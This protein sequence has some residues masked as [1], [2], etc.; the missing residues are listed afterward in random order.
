MN[1][2]GILFCHCL[3]VLVTCINTEKDLKLGKVK[4]MVPTGRIG[5]CSPAIGPDGTVYI[6]DNEGY[7]Y[8][9]VDMDS[10][11]TFKWAPVK[12]ETDLGECCPTLTSD[13][14]R[15]YIGS[16]T[17]PASMFCINTDDGSLHWKYT[18]PPNQTLYG[19]G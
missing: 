11:W 2:R 5:W 17:R 10:T 1:I 6:G 19:G 12:L 9:V 13:G 16:N 4:W 15:L 3:I 18:L 7:L 14:K 8:A